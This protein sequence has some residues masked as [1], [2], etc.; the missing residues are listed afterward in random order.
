MRMA[1]LASI[2]IFAVALAA[3]WTRPATTALACN[4]AYRF[5]FDEYVQDASLIAVVRLTDP[6]PSPTATATAAVRSTVSPTA[7]PQFPS[8]ATPDRTRESANATF[9]AIVS[10]FAT[11]TP[12]VGT[13][14]A[15]L[16][17]IVA[18][19]DPGN[20]LTRHHA[21]ATSSR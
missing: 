2:I 21:M 1:T 11:K 5:T 6:R 4:G 14:V 15:V 10:A 20:S 17:R 16:E 9:A 18:G 13:A 3:A 8:A 7:T 19:R 12:F